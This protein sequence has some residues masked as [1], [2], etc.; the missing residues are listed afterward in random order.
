MAKAGTSSALR[1]DITSGQHSVGSSL[2]EGL[3]KFVLHFLSQ[4]SEKGGNMFLSLGIAAC[5]FSSV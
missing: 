1:P 5:I 3:W 4:G 2:A